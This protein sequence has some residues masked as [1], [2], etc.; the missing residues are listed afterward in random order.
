MEKSR[1]K[2]DHYTAKETMTDLSVP[3]S[4]KEGPT[5]HN[6][7]QAKNTNQFIPGITLEFIATFELQIYRFTSEF[8]SKLGLLS[9]WRIMHILL[10]IYY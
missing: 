4:K 10:E 2:R 5:G 9:I 6:S 1:I 8:P 3:L 7:R